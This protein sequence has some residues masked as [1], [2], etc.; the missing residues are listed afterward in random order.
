MP[1][2]FAVFGAQSLVANDG[3]GC[4]GVVCYASRAERIVLD[5]EY[6]VPYAGATAAHLRVRG[7]C[8]SSIEASVSSR[9]GNGYGKAFYLRIA[10]TTRP[11][12]KPFYGVFSQ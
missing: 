10:S 3:A 11:P 2:C 8:A 12:L 5:F 1:W 4:N 6:D 7:P 9:D